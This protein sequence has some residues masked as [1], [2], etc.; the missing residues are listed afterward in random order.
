MDTTPASL[1]SPPSESTSS[2]PLAL[3]TPSIT[4]T[5]FLVSAL[6]ALIL[7][8]L[9]NRPIIRWLKLKRYQYEVTF[10]LYMLTPMEKFVFSELPFLL[11]LCLFDGYNS[12]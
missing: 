11:C 10:S 9:Y 1:R 8:F 2:L 5:L 6:T 4:T 3:S 12:P 7:L